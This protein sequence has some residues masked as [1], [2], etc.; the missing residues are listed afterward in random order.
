MRI[1]DDTIR[2]AR[3]TDLVG[4]LESMN[5]TLEKC[6]YNEWRIIDE[7]REKKSEQKTSCFVTGNCFNRFSNGNGGNAIDFCV[8][9]LGMNPYEAVEALIAYQ[10]ITLQKN[11]Q[12][13]TEQATEH[14]RRIRTD[15]FSP[16]ELFQ[17]NSKRAIAYLCQ[18]RMID[19]QV[20][21]PLLTEG[22]LR[23]D[24]RGNACFCQYNADNI[25][26]GIEKHGTATSGKFCKTEGEK[27]FF[28][29]VGKPEIICIFESAIDLLS[30]R[31]MFFNKVRR[32]LL[33]SMGGLN[34]LALKLR[35]QYPDSS[36]FLCIDNDQRGNEFADKLCRDYQGQF[37]RCQTK[38]VKDWNDLL[39]IRKTAK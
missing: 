3:Q 37:S 30:F 7:T 5:Y 29:K 36:V 28:L 15:I 38:T 4:F 8:Q 9:E 33:V 12:D 1:D 6:G 20:I 34:G 10:G 14:D 25:L 19:Y 16:K 31:E 2:K 21:R 39:K 17:N 35:K 13:V 23:Q 26:I 24:V 18:T 27:G 11:Q 22:L 32:H